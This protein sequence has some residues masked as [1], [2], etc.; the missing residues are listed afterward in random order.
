MSTKNSYESVIIRGFGHKPFVLSKLRAEK[1][2][3]EAFRDDES[4]A[5]PF[6][7]NEVFRYDPDVWRELDAAAKADDPDRLR[8]AWEKAEP[9][10]CGH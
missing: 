9:W 3:V 4:V 7:I 10:A 2:F 8:A 6:R 1:T 5:M